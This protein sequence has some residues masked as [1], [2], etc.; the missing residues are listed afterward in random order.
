MK[1]GNKS[2]FLDKISPKSHFI[3][4]QTWPWE[5]TAKFSPMKCTIKMCD[6]NFTWDLQL[7]FQTAHNLHSEN[8]IFSVRTMT[9][10][11]RR[12]P[13]RQRSSSEVVPDIRNGMK[14]FSPVSGWM[15]A[16]VQ[17]AW[18]HP[19]ASRSPEV[20]MYGSAVNL[21]LPV[22]GRSLTCLIFWASQSC[23]GYVVKLRGRAS[24]NH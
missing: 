18:H 6:V 15:M 10:M 5:W 3:C 21:G 12:E 20:W 7:V 17:R 9:K 23:V 4:T 24:I 16:C 1:P 13:L 2:L 19:H 14:I 11:D 22:T 8:M